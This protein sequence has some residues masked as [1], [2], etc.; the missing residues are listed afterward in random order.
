MKTLIYI[1]AF[2]FCF[3]ALAQEKTEEKKETE[4]K[5]EVKTEK[6]KTNP[7]DIVEETKVRT[8]KVEKNGEVDE[9]KV[10]V[11]TKQ[12]QE[13]KTELQKEHHENSNR[14]DSPVKVTQSVALDFD[15]DPFYDSESKSVYYSNQDNEYIFT[16]NDDGFTVNLNDDSNDSVYGNAR[17]TSA[18]RY[19]LL[20]TNDYSGI[21]YFNADGSFVVEYYDETLDAMVVRTFEISNM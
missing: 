17:L 15:N 9:K 5:T 19:Y 8:M 20:K 2:L 14:V 7:K 1:G 10:K 12:E 21:G 13:V 18:N 16:R 6:K 3:T 4:T 11:T